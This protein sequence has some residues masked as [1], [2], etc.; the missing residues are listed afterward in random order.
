[1]SSGQKPSFQSRLKRSRLL[2]AVL[3]IAVAG[4]G[5]IVAAYS[6]H[7]FGVETPTCGGRPTGQPNSAYFTVVM[8]N[9]G[10]NV[11]FNGSKYQP[12]PWPVMNVTLGETVTIHVMNNDTTQ[13]HGFAISHYFNS[14][15]TLRPGQRYDATFCADQAGSFSVYCNIFC[16]IHIFMQNGRLNVSNS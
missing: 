5:S 9:E 8:A 1:M 15:I 11:G 16:T 10:M 7:L 4:T 2:L 3:T 13:P 14:G 12:A 6:F